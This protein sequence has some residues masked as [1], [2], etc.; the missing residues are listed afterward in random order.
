MSC[1]ALIIDMQ[2][3]F[4][5]HE[6]LSQR[7]AVLTQH[8]N[9]LVEI[10]RLGRV[11]VVWVKQEF[12][13]DLSDALLEVKKNTI[14][15]VIAGTPGASI[16]Q[17]LDYQASD[18]LVVKKRYSA[19]FGTDLDSLLDR[20]QPA[21]LIIAGINTHAC[22]R[23]TV[24]DAYQR[25]YEIVLA[26]DCIESHDG[27]HHEVSW[28]YMDGKLARSMSNEQIGSLIADAT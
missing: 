11:H 12:A 6:R 2:E 9:D 28:R 24:I 1:A 22:V 3:D 20:I 19:F 18:H 17:E 5:A 10:C 8:V 27:E 7:R 16:L 21:Q 23:T 14:H 15:I 4:F 25:D 26:R 13:P